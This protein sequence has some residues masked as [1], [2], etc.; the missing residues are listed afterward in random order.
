MK[1][2]GYI[3]LLYVIAALYD[4]LLGGAFLFAGERLFAW[5]KVTPPNHLG[6]LHFPA[7]LLIVFAIMFLAIAR[8]PA[9]NRNLIPYAMLLKVSYC[10]VVLFHW[11]TAGIPDMWK[12]FGI[13]D[14]LF[15][16]LFAWSAFALRRS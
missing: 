7:A 14:L 10:G 2:R 16:V 6:Y 3:K 12:P 13:C 9:K 15:F 4:G 8:N 5:F 1:S 11:L